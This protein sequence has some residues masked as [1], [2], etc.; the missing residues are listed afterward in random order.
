MNEKS[1]LRGAE[2]LEQSAGTNMTR[3]K[4]VATG[5]KIGYAAPLVAASFKLAG[6][7]A[8]AEE[9]GWTW[10]EVIPLEDDVTAA[11]N[12]NTDTDSTD[13]PPGHCKV[14]ICH[15]TCSESG[16][17]TGTGYSA[18]E[19]PADCEDTPAQALTT[20]LLSGNH[21]NGCQDGRTDVLPLEVTDD[22]KLAKCPNGLVVNPLSF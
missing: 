10:M 1:L 22:K 2:M 6:G 14:V 5:I 15:A 7:S 9:W 4:V 8:L 13:T 17:N 21:H 19:V 20:H 12:S 16:G 18:I 3:R 11:R